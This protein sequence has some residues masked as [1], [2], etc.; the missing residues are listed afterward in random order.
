LGSYLIFIGKIGLWYYN[1]RLSVICLSPPQFFS[2]F[3]DFHEIRYE[4]HVT[5]NPQ[6][7]NI[8]L[9]LMPEISIKYWIF[10]FVYL[11]YAL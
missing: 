5:G 1:V 2:H 9:F 10:C 7:S 3:T 4:R 8:T 11:R 6:K